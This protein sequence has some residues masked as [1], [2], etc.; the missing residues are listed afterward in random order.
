MVL[1]SWTIDQLDDLVALHGD[2]VVTQYLTISGTVW[3]RDMARAAL[4]SWIGLYET[5]R[6]GKLRVRRKSDARFI[7]RAGFGIYAGEPELGYTFFRE[8][9]GQGYATE[10]AAGLRDWYFASTDEPRFIGLADTRNTA[11]IHVL[12]KIGMTPTHVAD[13]EGGLKTQFLKM[14]R[15]EG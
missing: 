5:R 9:W 7:G 14:E 11:S 12:K 6:L 15:P 2:P 1:E 3:T 4:E 13:A 10:A 8:H